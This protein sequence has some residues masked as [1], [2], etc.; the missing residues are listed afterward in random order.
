MEESL[1]EAEETGNGPEISPEPAPDCPGVHLPDSLE[2]QQLHRAILGEFEMGEADL[3]T[4][5][6]LALAFLGDS[7]YSTV[8]RTLVTS[9]GS[10]QA[11]KLHNEA[12]RLVSAR[13]QAAVGDA[14]Q[15]ELTEE[16]LAVYR[17][18][19]NSHPGHMA[20]NQT[21]EDYMKATALEAL[22]AQLYMQNRQHRLLALIRAGLEK[23]GLW[24]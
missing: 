15:P 7:V 21:P 17:R 23:A 3:R 20:K 1:R 2:E 5:S 24:K 14:I 10:R 22:C 19:L 4:Y 6:P 11:E 9:R 13:A 8:I 16:E 12:S 18:G